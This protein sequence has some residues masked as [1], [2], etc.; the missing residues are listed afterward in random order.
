M[1]QCSLLLKYT[2]CPIGES[3]WSCVLL[4]FP[5]FFTELPRSKVTERLSWFF[6]QFFATRGLNPN[7]YHFMCALA[8]F[9]FK[10]WIPYRKFGPRG[11]VSTNETGPWNEI[12]EDMCRYRNPSS[13]KGAKTLEWRVRVLRRAISPREPFFI[14]G[15]CSLWTAND[16]ARSAS[17]F[18]SSVFSLVPPAPLLLHVNFF[19]TPKNGRWNKQHFTFYVSSYVLATPRSSLAPQNLLVASTRASLK[20]L[21]RNVLSTRACV[22]ATRR[23]Q[24]SP[25]LTKRT[26][27]VDL[28]V[29]YLL[30]P[31]K[32]ELW[33]RPRFVL[34]ALLSRSPHEPRTA[35]R[36][37]L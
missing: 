28:N 36:T 8:M 2:C 6:V 4:S 14:S 32:N 34:L 37:P 12:R 17:I 31:S 3:F 19:L 13:D 7:K 22:C 29:Q 26:L 18:F 25:F 24:T 1:V 23:N 35:L 9:S 15:S 5:L 27:P 30:L 16:D 20:N 21:G 10:V 11:S 33:A